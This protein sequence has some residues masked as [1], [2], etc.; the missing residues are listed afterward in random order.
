MLKELGRGGMGEV[1]LARDTQSPKAEKMVALKILPPELTRNPQYVERF[2]R[3]AKAISR[4]DHPHIIKVFEIGEER[5]I[6]YIAMEYLGGLP[7]G[8]LL[9]KRGRLPFAEAARIVMDVAEALEV[10]HSKGIIHR[11]IKPDNILSDES[12]E[13]KVMDFG[14]ARMEDGAQLTMTGTIMGTPEYMSPEQAGGKKVDKRTDIYSLGIVF[15]EMLTG[16][17]PFHAETALEVIQMH[18]N[19]TPESPKVLNPDIPGNLAGVINKMVEKNPAGRYASFRHVVNAIGQAIPKASAKS[20]QTRTVAIQPEKERRAGDRR[21]GGRRVKDRRAPDARVREKIVTR[22][23]SGVKAAIALSMVLNIALFGMYMAGGPSTEAPAP[24]RGSF[25]LGSQVFA[26]PVEADGTMYIGAQN[27]RLYALDLHSGVVKWTFDTGDQITAAPL[28]DGARVYVGSWDKNVYALDTDGLLLWKANVGDIVS[29]APVL[30]DG[31]L[32]VTT[33]NGNV[34]ALDA[35]TGSANWKDVTSA[36]PRFSPVIHG[37]TLFVD[38]DREFLAYNVSAGKR[39]GGFPAGRLKTAPVSV[40]DRLYY[41]QFDDMSGRDELRL[42]MIEPG[43]TPDKL[44]VI[45]PAW[46]IPL[47][48][49]GDEY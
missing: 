3:E 19:Q 43:P 1:Y 39:L 13:F 14:I 7:L 41:I 24:A 8:D 46:S 35:A 33:R 26:P 4:L 45:Q 47:E 12:G 9:R 37:D 32:F 36:A 44:R 22:I 31:V 40:E 2:R 27:G 11:D 18:I 29:G 15:Y 20:V 34:Y 38:G 21:A 28:V 42:F 25:M 16:K 30:F 49:A 6:H 5:G 17:V 10:A 23:P 48:S